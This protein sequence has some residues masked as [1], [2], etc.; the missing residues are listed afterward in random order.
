MRLLRPDVNGKAKSTGCCYL[1]QLLLVNATTFL[2]AQEHVL[3]CRAAAVGLEAQ[4]NQLQVLGGAEHCQGT[5]PANVA[6]HSASI[7]EEKHA[8]S[9]SGS[10]L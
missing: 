8:R 4:K 5:S 9:A 1:P 10:G 7:F 6:W 2:K 3:T